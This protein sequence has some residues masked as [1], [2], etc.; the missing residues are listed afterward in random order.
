ME[1][2]VEEVDE[3][4]LEQRIEEESTS[5]GILPR[6]VPSRRKNSTRCFIFSGLQLTGDKISH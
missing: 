4:L 5:D 2:L 1:K 3:A 6:A